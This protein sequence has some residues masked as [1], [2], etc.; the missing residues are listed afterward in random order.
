MRERTG[1][2]ETGA[3]FFKNVACEYFPCHEGVDEADF[4]CLFCYCP[5]YALGPGCGGDYRYTERGIKDCTSC[6]RLHRGADGAAIVR[7]RFTELADLA[8]ASGRRGDGLYDLTPVQE[9]AGRDGR[10]DRQPREGRLA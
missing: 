4:N 9:E 1:G 5:L 2:H 7:S 8:R 3:F 6:V 10:A